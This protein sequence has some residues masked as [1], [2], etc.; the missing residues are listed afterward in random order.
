MGEL[1]IW[2]SI[3]SQFDSNILPL[4]IIPSRILVLPVT[5]LFRSKWLH[6]FLQWRSKVLPKCWHLLES[7]SK[8]FNSSLYCLCSNLCLRGCNPL[9]SGR[10]RK[11]RLWRGSLLLE[12]LSSYYHKW[13]P[14][15]KK[16][17]TLIELI[18]C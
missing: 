15:L 12:G 4:L 17:Q 18:P 16:L 3:S 6:F 2:F 10:Q 9:V 5:Q 13:K 14:L 11:E 8:D 1:T 7:Q